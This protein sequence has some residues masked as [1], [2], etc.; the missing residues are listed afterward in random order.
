MRALLVLAGLAIVVGGCRGLP[1]AAGPAAETSG[2]GCE[3]AGASFDRRVEPGSV[4]PSIDW[5]EPPPVDVAGLVRKSTLVVVGRAASIAIGSGYQGETPPGGE[6]WELV[7][8]EV[9]RTLVGEA[10]AELTVR[11]LV[12]GTL[13]VIAAGQRYVLFLWPFEWRPNEPTGEWYVTYAPMGLY[14]LAGD[15]VVVLSD[16][17][18]VPL[19]AGTTLAELEAEIAAATAAAG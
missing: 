3:A 11:Q 13:P 6:Q 5:V 14:G 15:C 7:T 1:L 12:D 8:V 4:P 18:R 16:A 2:V 17:Y 19:P 9:E 10:P